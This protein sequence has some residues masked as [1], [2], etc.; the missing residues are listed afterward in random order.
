M[1]ALAAVLSV[2]ILTGIVSAQAPGTSTNEFLIIPGEQFGLIRE[3]TTR[4]GLERLFPRRLISDEEVYLGEGFCTPGTRI[5]P[6]TP[7]EADIAWQDASKSMVAFIRTTRPGGNWITSRG[8]R[9][10]TSLTELERL[11]GKVVTFSGFGWDY[12][13]GLA[14][15][16]SGRILSLR[17]SLD[18][19]SSET[20]NAAPNS[21]EI[22]GDQLVRSDHPLIRKLKVSV[23]EITQRWGAHYGE[24]ECV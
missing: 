14:W 19:A 3:S 10:G 22:F 18:S 1:R 24:H 9:I 2:L 12:G 17:L 7:I 11:A 4:A 15:E 6:G 21:R 5:F 13:G 8:V 23:V 16:E 20:A